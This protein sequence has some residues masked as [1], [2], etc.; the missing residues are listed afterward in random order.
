MNQWI[1]MLIG[2]AFAVIVGNY[3]VRIIVDRLWKP[4]QWKEK[5]EV[6]PF[7][8]TSKLV[9]II[10]RNLY[11]FSILLGKPEFIAVWFALKVAG[12]WGRWEGSFDIYGKTIEGRI[13]YNI[14]LIGSGLSLA[15][16]VVG[17]LMV[18]SLETGGYENVG[19]YMVSILVGTYILK[20]Y[21]GNLEENDLFVQE[22][23]EKYPEKK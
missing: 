6:R 8:Y 18:D 9:G 15:Y 20:W 12:Q 14:F 21:I 22:L 13:F 1:S 10:E 4:T 5:S 11:F 2:W 23:K 7:A 16:A 17:A 3:V 19:I